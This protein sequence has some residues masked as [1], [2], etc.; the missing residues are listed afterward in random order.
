M[1]IAASRTFAPATLAA[2]ALLA[3][4]P[5]ATYFTSRGVMAQGATATFESVTGTVIDSGGSLAY[6]FKV[7]AEQ[8]TSCRD[9]YLPGHSTLAARTNLTVGAPVQVYYDPMHPRECV[10]TPGTRYSDFAASGASFFGLP[11]LAGGLWFFSRRNKDVGFA[12]TYAFNQAQASQASAQI[13]RK[14]A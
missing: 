13:H 12:S 2:V 1:A 6:T 5:I 9:S 11:M 14:A 3:A 8:F 10:L 4:A 7:G